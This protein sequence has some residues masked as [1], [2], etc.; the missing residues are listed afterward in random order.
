MTEQQP[1]T[2]E[3]MVTEHSGGTASQSKEGF[4]MSK[5]VILDVLNSL[6]VIDSN[7]GDDAYI[8]VANTQ[9]VR[10]RLA[11]AGVVSAAND[12][13]VLGR[14]GDEDEFCILA[15]AFGDGYANDYQ[16]GKLVWISEPTNEGDS[17]P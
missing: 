1:M 6:P 8:L 11:A 3:Q 12:P 14:Y 16:G 15:F 17:R 2:A 10:E 13:D 9:E 7:G 5:Q 4:S